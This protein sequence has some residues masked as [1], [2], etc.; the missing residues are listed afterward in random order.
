LCDSCAFSQ[1]TLPNQCMECSIC[2]RNPRNAS[3][4][5]QPTKFKDTFIE[6]PIDMYISKEL[7]TIM[8]QE[9]K[10]IYEEAQKKEQR[11]IPDFSLPPHNP[12]APRKWWWDWDRG[13]YTQGLFKCKNLILQMSS[14][15][16]LNVTWTVSIP[17]W[18][19][20]TSEVVEPK[21][22]EISNQLGELRGFQLEEKKVIKNVCINFNEIL[23]AMDRVEVG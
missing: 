20:L 16:T 3:I 15:D 11:P 1:E 21:Q 10:K 8:M 13:V 9:I 6:K 4:K 23:E 5:F 18:I 17:T 19:P 14:E 22:L 12:Y 2:I 7:M